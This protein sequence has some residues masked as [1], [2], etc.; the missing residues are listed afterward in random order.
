MF[1]RPEVALLREAPFRKPGGRGFSVHA[2]KSGHQIGPSQTYA[3]LL[4]AWNGKPRDQLCATQ[5][6]ALM[7][8][9]F[10]KVLVAS[11]AVAVFSCHVSYAMWARTS[12][13]PLGA[14]LADSGLENIRANESNGSS[15][16]TEQASK[17]NNFENSIS[18]ESVERS[19][20]ALARAA[21]IHG[22]PLG[23]FTRLIRQESNFD[24]KAISRAGAQGIAQF[25]PATAHWRGLSNPFEPTQALLESARWLHELHEEFGN[26]GL[27]AAAYNAGPRRVKDWMAGR[28]QLP[29]ETRAY[30]RIITGRTADDWRTTPSETGS[31]GAASGCGEVAKASLRSVERRSEHRSDEKTLAGIWAIQLISDA[32]ESRALSEYAGLQKRYRSVLGDRA[33]VI[34]KRPIG[35]R[36]PSSWYF[37]RVAESSHQKANQLCSR[38]KSVGG[39]CLVSRN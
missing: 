21:A 18:A 29:N 23:F 6:D 19:N 14:Q 16:G 4:L 22:I 36:A 7:P 30:V 10:V 1:W 26:L 12:D 9:H 20:C 11:V 38:L 17:S 2:S 33:P 5:G 34:I 39:A 8:L 37:I 3:S 32:S 24:T 25:M 28:G 27:A 13:G 35:G 15:A 31:L